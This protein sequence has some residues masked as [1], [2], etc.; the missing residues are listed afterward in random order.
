VA[1]EDVLAGQYGAAAVVAEVASP[2][3]LAL[4]SLEQRDLKQRHTYVGDLM[5]RGF[6]GRQVVHPPT[7][8]PCARRLL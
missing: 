2:G 8:S 6:F 7:C 3:V 4:A 1:Q 5:E